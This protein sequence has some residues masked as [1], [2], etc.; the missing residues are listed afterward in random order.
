MAWPTTPLTSYLP[1]S[2]PAVK[3]ADLNAIQSAINRAFLGTYSFSGLVLDGAG[4]APASPPPGGL[5]AIGSASF[6]GNLTVGASGAGTSLPTP[7][8]TKNALCVESCLLAFAVF[9]PVFG[10][11]S[12]YC[13]NIQSITLSSD[14]WHVQLRTPGAPAT[15]LAIASALAAD[16]FAVANVLP[17][18]IVR[19][20]TYYPPGQSSPTGGPNPL[21]FSLLVFGT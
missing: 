21:G 13:F 6:G 20:Q 12:P 2:L 1:G 16:M 18:G 3:A 19:V 11:R 8:V 5:N 15:M 14:G 10:G 7:A 17:S 4:G 9:D